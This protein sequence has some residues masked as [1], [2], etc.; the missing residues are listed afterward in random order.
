MLSV[1]SNTLDKQI[2]TCLRMKDS[3]F[4]VMLMW[5]EKKGTWIGKGFKELQNQL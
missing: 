4:R 3:K 2:Q 1:D 5:E